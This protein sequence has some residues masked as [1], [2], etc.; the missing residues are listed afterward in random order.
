M[1]YWKNSTALIEMQVMTLRTA[2][3]E[4]R[5]SWFNFCGIPLI[6]NFNIPSHL[7]LPETSDET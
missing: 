1:C 6:Y 5:T 3:S 7:I 4:Y 2:S